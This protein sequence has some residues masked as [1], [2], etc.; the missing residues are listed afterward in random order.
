MTNAKEELIKT[1]KG[2]KSIVKCATIRCERHSY[3][4]DHDNYKRSESIYLIEGYTPTE[5]EEFL[6]KLDFEYDAGYG[7]QE[8][9]GLVWL[10]EENTWLERGEYDGSEWW[11]FQECPPIPKSL[12]KEYSQNG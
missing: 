7:G 9:Y 4:D 12:M 5:Y 3:W 10:M 6:Q 2:T 11:N 8:L 1:L